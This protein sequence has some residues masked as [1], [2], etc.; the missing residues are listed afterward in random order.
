MFENNMTVII[1]FYISSLLL[2]MSVILALIA[3][4]LRGVE[5]ALQAT[6]SFIFDCWCD[7]LDEHVVP[8]PTVEDNLRGK[9]PCLW[10]CNLISVVD[11]NV[12]KTLLNYNNK[13]FK[14]R[15]STKISYLI[16]SF[17]A[18]KYFIPTS[19]HIFVFIQFMCFKAD[20]WLFSWLKTKWNWL[21]LTKVIIKVHRV[22]HNLSS[23]YS[24]HVCPSLLVS[25]LRTFGWMLLYF[26]AESVPLHFC[27]HS[28]IYLVFK[29]LL[30]K[31]IGSLSFHTLLIFCLQLLVFVIHS[32]NIFYILS[33]KHSTNNR[34]T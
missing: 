11:R 29:S 15:M 27:T 32:V 16:P 34:V 8:P 9:I 13:L 28:I 33:C 10:K 19:K 5:H 23:H 7:F 6:H 12:E 17:R 3:Q 4:E 31:Y 22:L 25:S 21:L 1:S 2:I 24:F 18:K 14:K 26:S 20:Y 30:N